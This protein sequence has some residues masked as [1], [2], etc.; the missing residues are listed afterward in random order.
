MTAQT[1]GLLLPPTSLDAYRIE[2]VDR[3]MTPALAIYPEIVD[4]NIKRRCDYLAG[5]PIDGAR[6]SKPRSSV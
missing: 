1:P 5:T 3:V 6:T 2:G 4:E